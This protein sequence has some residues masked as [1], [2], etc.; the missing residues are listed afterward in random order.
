LCIDALPLHVRVLVS[1]VLIRE[2]ANREG[3][4]QLWRDATSVPD[5]SLL[6]SRDSVLIPLFIFL[7]G[8]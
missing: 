8:L 2:D 1:C 7:G 4:G 5:V 3:G 6:S